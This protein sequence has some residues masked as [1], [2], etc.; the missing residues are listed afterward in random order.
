[1]AV[2]GHD[3]VRIP[4]WG[5]HGC[6]RRFSLPAALVSFSS[7]SIFFK[8]PAS[9]ELKH[10]TVFNV[11]SKAADFKPNS[12]GRTCSGGSFSEHQD[13]VWPVFQP[14]LFAAQVSKKPGRGSSRAAA[15]E[16]P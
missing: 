3:G 8:L 14:C 5:G 4:E 9:G 15:H 7:S 13:R 2:L 10:L 16:W 6:F 1:M 11:A 12:S